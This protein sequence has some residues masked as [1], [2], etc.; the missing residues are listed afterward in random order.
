[1]LTMNRVIAAAYSFW[2]LF[3]RMYMLII[4]FMSEYGEPFP[5]KGNVVCFFLTPFFPEMY[6]VYIALAN[7]WNSF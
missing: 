2:F 6:F 4:F 1:M 7:L 5:G 3:T